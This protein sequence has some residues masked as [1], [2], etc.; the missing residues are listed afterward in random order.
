MIVIGLLF[1][2]F[3]LISCNSTTDIKG[4]ELRLISWNCDNF[5]LSLDTLR[6]A[7]IFINNQDPDI[8]CLQ[9]RPHTNLVNYDSI[10]KVFPTLLYKTTNGRED[11]NLNIA[12]FSKYPLQNIKTWYFTGTYNKMIHA[13]ICRD[14]DTIRIFNVHLQT[15]GHGKDLVYN[16]RKRYRQ[17]NLL[18]EEIK[19]SPYPIIVCGDFNDILSSYTL[20]NLFTELRDRSIVFKGSYQPLCG[21]FKIDYVL[22]S[23]NWVKK[24]YR[25]IQNQWS[26]HKLQYFSGLINE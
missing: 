11:E 13:D 8:I 17:S 16:C 6:N 7:A 15:T 12:I 5:Q 22:T 23:R 21:L 10:K 9:E 18:K 3:T 24:E 1:I 2:L 25:L 4:Q 14:T 26:D 19:K 20:L